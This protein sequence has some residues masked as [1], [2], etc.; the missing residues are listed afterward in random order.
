MVR[1]P[2]RVP[3]V[4][5]VNVIWIAQVPPA[6]EAVPQLF[7]MEKSPL[8]VALET[9]SA[10]LPKSTMVTGWAHPLSLLLVLES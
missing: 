10:A 1:V 6:G 5:G 8:A 3:V 7:W 4:V 2:L 9:V